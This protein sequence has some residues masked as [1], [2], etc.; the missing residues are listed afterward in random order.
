MTPMGKRDWVLICT[1]AFIV[2]ATAGMVYL[3]TFPRTPHNYGFGPEWKCVP[4][5]RGHPTC[6]KVG[7]H[8]T[9]PLLQS[10]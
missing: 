5:M 3:S 8:A 6:V 10:N 4:A 1:A 2:V 7:P 9:D